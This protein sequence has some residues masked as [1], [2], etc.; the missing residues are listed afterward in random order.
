MN[1]TGKGEPLKKKLKFLAET[2]TKT[3]MSWNGWFWKNNNLAVMEIFLIFYEMTKSVWTNNPTKK[4]EKFFAYFHFAYIPN[5]SHF[6]PNTY[7]LWVD[8]AFAPPP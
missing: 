2:E 1:Q 7:I 3:R 6:S 4:F 8:K 5:I